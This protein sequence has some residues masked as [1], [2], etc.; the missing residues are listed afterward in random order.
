MKAFPPGL[1]PPR[2]QEE[3][4]GGHQIWKTISRGPKATQPLNGSLP[5]PVSSGPGV[6]SL[7][8]PRVVVSVV[9]DL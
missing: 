5:L 4:S 9:L 7:V 8:W 3:L 1:P 6:L 2:T